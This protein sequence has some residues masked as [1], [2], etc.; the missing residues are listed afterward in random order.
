MSSK[1]AFNVA[2]RNHTASPVDLSGLMGHPAGY[3]PPDG[4]APKRPMTEAQKDEGGIAVLKPVK[5][6]KRNG[7][8]KGQGDGEGGPN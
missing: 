2:A 4:Q 8:R 7:G 1:K 6:R 3:V 5:V